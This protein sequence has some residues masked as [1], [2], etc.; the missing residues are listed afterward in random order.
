MT[1]FAPRVMDHVDVEADLSGEP[2]NHDPH[3]G[4]LYTQAAHLGADCAVAVE[5]R[6]ATFLGQ[7]NEPSIY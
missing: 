4:V 1:G 2:E 7:T 6:P 3:H 5:T